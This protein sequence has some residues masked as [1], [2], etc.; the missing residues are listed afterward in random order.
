[1]ETFKVVS[2]IVKI[3]KSIPKWIVRN[4]TKKKRNN[5]ESSPVSSASC[6][7]GVATISYSNNFSRLGYTGCAV[8]NMRFGNTFER[9]I[10]NLDNDHLFALGPGGCRTHI[11]KTY[12]FAFSE[13][14][15][16]A[17]V[18]EIIFVALSFIGL[19]ACRPSIENHSIKMRL[20][21]QGTGKAFI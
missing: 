1:M 10:V 13:I 2:K 7:R 8:S 3:I 21:A 17:W 18:W 12:L 9:H 20:S 15:A 11:T 4:K 19:L 5:K 16:F 6:S 14:I